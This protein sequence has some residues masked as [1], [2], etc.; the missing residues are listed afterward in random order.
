MYV[1]THARPYVRTYIRTY[2]RTY[3]HTPPGLQPHCTP[4][5][6]PRGAVLRTPRPMSTHPRP[7]VAAGR[8]HQH[9][10]P[11]LRAASSPEDGSSPEFQMQHPRPPAGYAR[12]L[13]LAACCPPR[14]CVGAL[15]LTFVRALG[16]ATCALLRAAC[17]ACALGAAA[18]RQHQ[19]T[20]SLRPPSAR[21]MLPSVD[22]CQRPL[23]GIRLRPVE[24][25][26]A[27]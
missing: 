7:G 14:T 17:L 19:Q 25:L 15:L 8:Q 20:P 1:R 12:A 27:P 10:S 23:A 11:P 18:G 26:H 13:L 6:G 21:S 5:V 22:L 9:L 2:V 3:V 4:R 16:G 24:E